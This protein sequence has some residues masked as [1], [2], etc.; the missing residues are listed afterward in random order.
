MRLANIYDLFEKNSPKEESIIDSFYVKVKS[1]EKVK[2]P[3]SSVRSD[4]VEDLSINLSEEAD[5]EYMHR[6]LNKESYLK[7]EDPQQQE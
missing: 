2:S 1:K 6:V 3:H 7:F 4:E 5:I